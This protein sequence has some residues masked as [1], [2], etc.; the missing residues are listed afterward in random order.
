MRTRLFAMSLLL[1]GCPAG[2]MDEPSRGDG[3]EGDLLGADLASVAP[4][5]I[6]DLDTL[7]QDCMLPARPDPLLLKGRMT[8]RN[9]GGLTLGP[10]TARDGTIFD[11]DGKQVATFQLSDLALGTIPPN[12]SIDAK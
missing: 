3:G 5:A 1:L 10:I 2:R 11:K 6:L 8:I 7:Y 12:G 9:Q 4:L